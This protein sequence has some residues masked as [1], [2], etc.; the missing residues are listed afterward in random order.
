MKR[1]VVLVAAVVLLA[2][3]TPA[4]AGD[5]PSG[6]LTVFAAASVIDVF[7]RLAAEFREEHPGVEVTISYGASSSSARAIVEGAPVDVF[8]SADEAQ[9]RVVAD[10][11]LAV[12]PVVFAE[13]VLT[14]AVPEGNP[15][16]ITG[17]A[18]FARED[19]TLALC[20][21]AVPC[22][23][24]AERLL[25]AVGIDAVPDTY[26]QDARAALNKVEL[27]EVDAALVYVTDAQA[28]RQQVDAVDVPD[29]DLA[30][31][32]YPVSVL[33]EAPNPEAAQAF[34]DLV[35]SDAGRRALAD[36]GF[37]AP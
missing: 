6:A 5:G 28:L 23:A 14:V 26:E 18:D 3:C 30:V 34:V 29:A 10:A 36:L 1:R 21:P 17:L 2:G 33:E 35:L 25:A 27:G 32:R 9:M 8:A 4:P 37:R 13:N 16:G 11:G 24:A 20:E 19:L 15:A 12:D 31:N 22:G 7:D